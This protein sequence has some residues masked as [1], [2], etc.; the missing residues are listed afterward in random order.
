MAKITNLFLQLTPEFGSVRYGPFPS[1]IVIGSDP[2][3]CQIILDPSMG[4]FPVHASLGR[5][6]DGSLALSP[7][8]KEAKLFLMPSGQPHTWPVTGPVV[9]NLGDLIV[10]GTPAGPRFQIQ[11]DLPRSAAPSAAQIL[12]TAQQSGEQGFIQSMSQAIDSVFRPSGGGISGEIQ[13]QIVARS[14]AHNPVIRDTYYLWSRLRTGSLFTP[15]TVVALLFATLSLIGTGSLSC[16]GLL[17]VLSDAIG[18]H[19]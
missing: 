11:S 4:I 3:R 10:L 16:S 6:A 15:Y 13:R 19:R 8:S 5:L 17:W 9:V 2:K 12:T 7:Q 1:S 14:L 18:L